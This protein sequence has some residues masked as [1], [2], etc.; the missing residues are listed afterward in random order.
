M[1]VTRSWMRIQDFFNHSSTLL[2][3]GIFQQCG[4][5]TSEKNDR[6]FTKIYHFVIFFFLFI[7]K[8]PLNFESR[9]YL[10]PE[11]G[12]DRI[13]L[14]GGQRAPNTFVCITAFT[15]Y[16]ISFRYNVCCDSSIHLSAIQACP[17]NSSRLCYIS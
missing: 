2:R 6:I 13:C 5:Y 14:G 1:E 15:L 4:S 10:S 3:W 16:F 17:L 12:S 7:I 11:S 8:S 9:P